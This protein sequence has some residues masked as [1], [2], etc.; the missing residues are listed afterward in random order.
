MCFGHRDQPN[1]N[2]WQLN[3]EIRLT[4]TEA[5]ETFSNWYESCLESGIDPNDVVQQM[6]GM[7]LLT[8][9][10]LIDGIFQASCRLNT[11]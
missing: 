8:D 9:E 3:L 1:N 2:K 11:A 6:G 5:Y 4:T 10:V 7:F